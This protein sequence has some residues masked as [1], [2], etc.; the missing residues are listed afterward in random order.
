MLGRY[1]LAGTSRGD[2]LMRGH[3]A[4]PRATARPHGSD[5]INLL[6]IQPFSDTA[7]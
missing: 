1:T 6:M 7:M 5:R 2:V 4:T 3:P